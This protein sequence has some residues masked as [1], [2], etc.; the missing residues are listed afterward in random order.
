[1]SIELKPSRNYPGRTALEHKTYP[2][3]NMTTILDLTPEDVEEL[4]QALTDAGH[5]KAITAAK[6]VAD[7]LQKRGDSIEES[8]NNGSIYALGKAGRG[9][10][11]REA[12]R[13]IYKALEG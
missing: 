6:A 13:N 12:A 11:Y 2:E 10:G 5:I 8:D 7:D 9:V 3:S 1:M 4:V